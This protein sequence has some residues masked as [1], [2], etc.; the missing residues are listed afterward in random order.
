M[1]YLETIDEKN[2]LWNGEC[3]VFDQRVSVKHGLELGTYSLCRSCRY[4]LN[5]AD[6]EHEH[7]KEG[8]HCGHCYLKLTPQQIEANTERHRQI[9]LALDRD[10]KHLGYK[11]SREHRIQEDTS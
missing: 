4:P 11:R 8:I 7:Y 2:S 6:M 1:K 9:L 5:S 10:T 3:Y